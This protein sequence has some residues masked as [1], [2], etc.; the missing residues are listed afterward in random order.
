MPFGKVNIKKLR[1]KSMFFKCRYQEYFGHVLLKGFL[2]YLSTKC[3]LSYCDHSPS[4]H[5][6]FSCLHSSIHKYQPISTKLGQNIC[7]HKFS[8]EFDYGCNQ[9]RTVQ[10]IC[11]N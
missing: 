11:L 5:P 9:T 10:V 6:Y 7:D 8:D 2:A 1:M 4:I 3:S